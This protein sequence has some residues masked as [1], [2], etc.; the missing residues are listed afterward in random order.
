MGLLSPKR[1]AIFKTTLCR[2]SEVFDF[3]R[4]SPADTINKLKP[5]CFGASAQLETAL[6]ELLTSSGNDKS[7]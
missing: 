1:I 6:N 3:E 2:N 4:L 5:N 7:L